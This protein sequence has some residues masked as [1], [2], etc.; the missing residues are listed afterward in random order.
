LD[1]GAFAG[2]QLPNREALTFAAASPA[3]WIPITS[4]RN[5]YGRVKIKIAASAFIR[6]QI[7]DSYCDSQSW[8]PV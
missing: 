8:R 6:Y 4:A 5:P 1:C 3:G 2:I 7:T